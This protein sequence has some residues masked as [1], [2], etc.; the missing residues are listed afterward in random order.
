MTPDPA[1]PPQTR[2]AIVSRYA[3]WGLTGLF[4]AFI[5]F[6]TSIKLMG[7]PAVEETLMGLGYPRG[8]GFGIGVLEAVLLVLYL[9][10]ATS[11]LGG[12][13]FVGVFGGAIASHV[14]AGSPLFTHVLF[15]VYLGLFAWGGLWL[16]DPALRRLFPLRRRADQSR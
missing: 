4:V 9:I 7:L 13:L 3:G 1:S 15:G 10:P 8:L 6:D 12:V 2:S 14:R 11:V 5:G 16:R